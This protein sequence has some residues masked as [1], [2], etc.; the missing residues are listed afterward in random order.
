MSLLSASAERKLRMAAYAEVDRLEQALRQVQMSRGAARSNA[1]KLRKKLA[2][3]RAL[4]RERM[5]AAVRAERAAHAET[6]ARLRHA[7]GQI[8]RLA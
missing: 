7:V 8:A 2:Q 6:K 3:E 5:R 1:T 4:N